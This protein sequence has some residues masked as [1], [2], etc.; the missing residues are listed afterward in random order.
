MG[1]PPGDEDVLV[2]EGDRRPPVELGHQPVEAGPG[3]LTLADPTQTPQD[4]GSA[5][6]A[7]ERSEEEALD[8]PVDRGDRDQ[9]ELRDVPIELLVEQGQADP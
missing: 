1:H 8:F 3:V 6:D 2:G 7:L 9:W 5:A 4:A